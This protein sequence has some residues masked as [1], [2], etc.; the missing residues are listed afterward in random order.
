MKKVLLIDE[1]SSPEARAQRLRRVRNIANL[2]REQICEDGSIN[3]YTYKGWEIARFGGL[4]YDG[5][6]RIVKQL[7]NAGVICTMDWLL[8]GQGIE[9]YIIPNF[10]H[11]KQPQHDSASTTADSSNQIVLIRNELY[12]FKNQFA[13]TIDYTVMD[14]GLSPHYNPGD[15]VAGVRRYNLD[16]QDLIN[17]NCIVELA[18]GRTLLRYMRASAT[19]EKYTLCCTHVNTT[20]L[21]P[22]I[23]DALVISAAKVIRHYCLQK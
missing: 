11:I 4:P 2:S 6:E 18:D 10:Q 3:I 16:I 20:A 15:V 14:D 13:D 23:Y 19:P 8:H 22:I 12:V 1:H 17:N 21:E 5:A 9:P 7:A